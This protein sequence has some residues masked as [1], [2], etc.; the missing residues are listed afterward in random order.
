MRRAAGVARRFAR[1]LA[2]AAM[3]AIGLDAVVS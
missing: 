1:A 2:A 3:A